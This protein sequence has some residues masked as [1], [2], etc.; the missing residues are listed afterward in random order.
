[1]LA[2]GTNL[3]FEAFGPHTFVTEGNQVVALGSER[4]SVKATGQTIAQEWAHVYTVQDGKITRFA[5]YED[6][7]A[8]AAA[9]AAD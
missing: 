1:V 6:T 9:F 5:A 8:L 3:D 7:A 2:N 4:S